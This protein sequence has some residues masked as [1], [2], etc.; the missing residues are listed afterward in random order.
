LRGLLNVGGAVNGSVGPDLGSRF[1][2]FI[3]TFDSQS[4]SLRAVYATVQ[5]L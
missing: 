3:P 2:W 4:R 1:I 5:E